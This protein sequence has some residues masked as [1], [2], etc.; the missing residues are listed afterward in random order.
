MTHISYDSDGHI[1]YLLADTEED[2]AAARAVAT[3]TKSEERL[4]FA[5]PSEPLTLRA[6]AIEARSLQQI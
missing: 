5:V 1:V 6:A 3:E 4:T 2:L